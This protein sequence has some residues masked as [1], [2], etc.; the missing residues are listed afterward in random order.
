MCIRVPYSVSCMIVLVACIVEHIVAI[1]F[2]R[3][4]LNRNTTNMLICFLY[5]KARLKCAHSKEFFFLY[6][7]SKSTT[8]KKSDEDDTEPTEESD[9]E[10]STTPQPISTT[11]TSKIATDGMEILYKGN[12]F[13]MMPMYMS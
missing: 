10:S 2:A 8:P 11:A 9:V 1:F 7:H 6:D 13:F 3:N 12:N 4:G 5:E